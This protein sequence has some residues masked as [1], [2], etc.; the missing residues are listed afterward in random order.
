MNIIV[1]YKLVKSNLQIVQ[2]TNSSLRL[3]FEDGE[4]RYFYADNL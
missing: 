2:V 4:I 3:N 1:N